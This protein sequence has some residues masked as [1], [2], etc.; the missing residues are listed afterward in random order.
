MKKILFGRKTETLTK[1][2]VIFVI[3]MPTILRTILNIP[4]TSYSFNNFHINESSIMYAIYL[5]SN[6]V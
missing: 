6:L 5:V 3:K 4:K 1:L 2:L